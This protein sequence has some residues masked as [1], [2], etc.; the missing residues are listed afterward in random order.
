MESVA[1]EVSVPISPR[2]LFQAIIGPNVESMVLTAISCL[3]MY[4]DISKSLSHVDVDAG[5]STL[6]GMS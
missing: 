6:G 2:A 3:R 4:A 5:L 1:F